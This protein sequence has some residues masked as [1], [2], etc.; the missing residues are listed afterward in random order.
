VEIGLIN[1]LRAGRNYKQVSRILGLLRSYPHV[2]HVETDRAGALPDAIDDLAR[3]KI[4]LL[5]IN[6]GDGTLQHTLTELL[7]NRPFGKVPMIAPLAGGR[8]NMTA[9]DLGALRNP[10]KGLEAVLDAAAAGTLHERIV[11]RPVIRVEFDGGRRVE[12]GMFF[13]AGMIRRAV[14]L[15]HDVFP[16]GSGQG[17]F[18]AGITTLA[19]VAKTAL[20]PKDGILTPDK[21]QIAL[22]DRP[23]RG[24][25]FYL[26]ISTTLRR[27]FW[28]IEP[29][30]GSQKG[31]LR[32]TSITSSAWRFGIAAPGILRG[33]PRGFVTPENGYTSRNAAQ[34]AL[35]MGCGFT[36]DGE[37]FDQQSEEVVRL[38]AG[39]PVSFIRA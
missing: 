11:D 29:F 9:L 32:F 31:D 28:G 19:L 36:V 20:K 39:R 15:V 3:R 10:V 7:V 16:N 33:K 38:S 1:N 18:G 35:S 27:L 30:W 6:G 13:G 14:S 23:V 8:T 21:I 5:V 22:D 12:Y 34:A 24:G 25:E 37:T 26:T 2:W 4:D 17:S